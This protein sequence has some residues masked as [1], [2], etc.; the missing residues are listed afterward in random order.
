MATRNSKIVMRYLILLPRK[1]IRF[2]MSFHDSIPMDKG[3]IRTRILV[4][5]TRIIM[6]VTVPNNIEF[7][8]AGDLKKSRMR[9]SNAAKRKKLKAWDMRGSM[10]Q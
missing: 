8:H 7:F 9:Y 6:P 1:R 3:R 10:K 4:G 5:R 2:L